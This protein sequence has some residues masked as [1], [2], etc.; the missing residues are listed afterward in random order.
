MQLGKHWT[1]KMI[2]PSRKVLSEARRYENNFPQI[3]DKKNSQNPRK[4]AHLSNPEAEAILE[5][6][7]LSANPS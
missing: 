7:Q 1:I 5:Q 6:S 3:A 4:V 2:V